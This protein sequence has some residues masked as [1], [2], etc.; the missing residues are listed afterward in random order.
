M[1][2]VIPHLSWDEVLSRR[3]DRHRLS[4]PSLSARPDEIAGAICGAHA[5]VLTAAELSIGLRIGGITRKQVQE[6]LWTE[7]SLVKTYGPRG[8]IHLLSTTELAMW[9]GALSA[10]PA[11]PGGIPEEVRLTPEQTGAIIEAIASILEDAELT[12][13][14]LTEALV[15]R[16]GP[17]AGESIEGGFQQSWPRWRQ[18][19]VTAANR[20]ALCFG[21]N[22]GR[23]VTYTHPRRWLPGFQP[24][25]EQPALAEVIKHYLFAY[26]PAAP[27]HFSRWFAAPQG[28][29][30][31]L[32]DSLSDSGE[33]QQVEVD[34]LPAWVVAGDVTTPSA[35]PKGLRLLPYFDAYA[36]GSHPREWVFPGRAFERA[37]AGGQAGN[38]PVLLINGAVGG[39]WHQRR[40]GR[41]LDITVEPFERLL[42]EQ[43]SELDDQVERISDFF[44][45]T[46][47][48]TIGTVTAGAHA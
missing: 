35:P 10:V 38:F 47:R 45:S 19:I 27:Q 13:D 4:S 16:V 12:S 6:A 48:L 40:S 3:L 17:W 11:S 1:R 8:T 9:T 26:G 21:P 31:T 28:W 29:V 42:A 44:D 43:R 24:A 7:R 32:F 2:N 39:V 41:M 46:P 14:E 33:L 23:K 36:V 5:Q 15:D 20:G 18:A 30:K 22:K 25:G 34:G 37:L